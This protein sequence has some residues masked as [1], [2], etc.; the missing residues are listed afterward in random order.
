LSGNDKAKRRN[1]RRRDSS[2]EFAAMVQ[3]DD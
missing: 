2:D 1:H 3:I